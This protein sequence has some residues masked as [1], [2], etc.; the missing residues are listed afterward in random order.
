M[1]TPAASSRPRP[2]GEASY[3]LVAGAAP[4]CK[5]RPPMAGPSNAAPP[6]RR[7]NT[8]VFSYF[9]ALIFLI[10]LASPVG[11][12][13]D[14]S[15]SYMLKNHLHATASEVSNFRIWTAIPIYLA[16]V[17]GFIRD[18]WNPFGTSGPRLPSHLRTGHRHRLRV[19]RLAAIDARGADVG[20]ARRGARV[21]ARRC[22][23]PGP[24]LAHRTGEVDVGSARDGLAD[25]RVDPRRDRGLRVGLGGAASR[26]EGDLLDACGVRAGPR[27]ASASGSPRRSTRMRT[28]TPKRG[29]APWS[30]TSN[31]CS[32]HKADLPGHPHQLHVELRAGRPPRHFSTTYP[33]SSTRA[34]PSTRISMQSS[35]RR[36]CPPSSSMATSAR[37][38]R[39]E[40]CSSGA[41]SRRSRR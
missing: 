2:S 41:R 38:S 19:A 8:Q 37:G 20:D 13:G 36:S 7:S 18:R 30:A 16:F 26:S 5:T 11:Y 27:S 40:A 34:T 12:L 9:G 23:V 24:P 28:R 25:R 35:P 32:S 39:F 3:A 22:G 10:T 4:I 15:T 6:G 1:G 21:S 14:I 31:G 33:T 29:T 17:F